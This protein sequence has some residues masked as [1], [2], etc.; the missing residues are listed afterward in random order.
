MNENTYETYYLDV[1]K[2]LQNKNFSNFSFEQAKEKIHSFANRNNLNSLYLFNEM[3]INPSLRIFFQKD[4]KKQNAAEKAFL[5]FFRAELPEATIVSLPN[6]GKN[7]LQ[8]ASGLIINA[9]DQIIPGAKTVDFIL[10]HKAKKYY[11]THKRTS[12]SGGAQKNQ[13]LDV[14][15]FLSEAKRNISP[16]IIFVAVLDGDFYTDKI[17]SETSHL[18]YSPNKV[19]I[20][21]S[22]SF[23]TYLKTQTID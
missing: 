10:K 17:R 8:L 11:I 14:H 9:S 3:K 18:F 20:H 13:L 19:L 21:T 12:G 4:P 6:G 7:S 1:I 22:D 5:K 23:L 15:N 2:E 16:D